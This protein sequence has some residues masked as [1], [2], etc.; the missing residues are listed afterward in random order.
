MNLRDLKYFVAVAD[1]GH[2]GQAAER[3]FVS[4]PTLSMQIRKLE[5]ELGV[6]LLERLPRKVKLTEAGELIYEKAREILRQSEA[7]KLTAEQFSK[8]GTGRL[9]LGAFPTLAPYLLPHIVPRIKRALPDVRLYLYEEKTQDLVDMLADGELDAALLADPVQEPSL[10]RM[11]LFR[12]H[13]LLA[14][15]QKHILADAKVIETASLATEP[16]LLLEDGHCLRDQ[17][18]EVCALAGTHEQ[19]EFRASS[20]ETL[21]HMVASGMGSTLLPELTVQPPV[22][23]PETL[24]FIPFASPQPK[25]DIALF[26]R[27]SSALSNLLEMV[28]GEIRQTVEALG[29]TGLDT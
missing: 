4:Q 15:D 13:F 6:S 21:R 28:G 26:W 8:P 12:E 18:L 5:D 2:F 14:V 10:K 22:Y 1:L 9:R 7:I 29:L 19:D 27:N 16:L 11:P 17:A 3:C 20:L 25:R 24:R 23:N